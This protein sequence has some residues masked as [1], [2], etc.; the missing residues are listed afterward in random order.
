MNYK[1]NVLCVG[2][3]VAVLL[4]AGCA[5]F[6]PG[7]PAGTID[8]I[9]HRG[10]SQRAP[11]N[12]LAAYRLADEMGADWFE[13][14]GHLTR[15]QGVILI[16]DDDLERTVGIKANVSD[17]DLE[18]LRQMDA[19]SWKNERFAGEPLPTFAEALNFAKNRIGV[20][21]EIKNMTDDTALMA[22]LLE[23]AADHPVMTP[24][25]ARQ[26]MDAIEA[27]GTRNLTLT[28]NTIA[29]VR[30]R[31]MEKGVVIQSFSPIVCAIARIEAP[32]MRVELLSG[33]EADKHDEWELVCRWVFLLDVHGLN[34]SAEGVTPG[35]LAAIQSAGKAMA[36]YTIDDTK[37]M[38]K[39]AFWGVDAIIT[40]CP[41]LCLRTLG[42]N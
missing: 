36:V 12:T 37:E 40:N 3:L 21:V 13:L 14:D 2:L 34:L 10:A 42:R 23:M 15:D 26:F 33:V 4:C 1:I 41:D 29:L 20:Y 32:D 30:E 28:R 17:Y 27:S 38:K 35:R 31:R 16:H 11:E 24:S 25:L 19:G 8:V 39:F 22:T 9:A 7:A 5:T 18:A 6:R